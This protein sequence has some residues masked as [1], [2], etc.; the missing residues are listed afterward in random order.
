MQLVDAVQELLG[1]VEIWPKLVLVI[2]LLL[3]LRAHVLRRL[4][5]VSTY[6]L[7]E[8]AWSLVLLD[9]LVGFLFCGK[10]HLMLLL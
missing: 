4:G 7:G 8:P 5:D 10:K 1:L 2:V 3:S 6:G 9:Y